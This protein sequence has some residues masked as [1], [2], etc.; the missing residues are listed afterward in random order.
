MPAKK[1]EQV[2][3]PNVEKPLEKVIFYVTVVKQCHFHNLFLR[4]S[5]KLRN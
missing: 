1:V 2:A 3:Q 4:L 5:K